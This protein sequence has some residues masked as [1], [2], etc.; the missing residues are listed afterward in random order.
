[1][2]IELCIHREGVEKVF[3]YLDVFIIV[4]PSVSDQCQIDLNALERVCFL[5]GVPLAAHISER[6]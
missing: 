6:V 1:M 3:H 5:L 4:A 2:L